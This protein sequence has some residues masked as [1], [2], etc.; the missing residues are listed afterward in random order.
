MLFKEIL[1]LVVI[2]IFKGIYF[3]K[4]VGRINLFLYFNNKGVEKG[5]IEQ[6]GYLI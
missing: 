4:V 2:V 3:S 5:L 6:I 1:Y